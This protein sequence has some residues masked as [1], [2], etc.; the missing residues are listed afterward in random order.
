MGLKKTKKKPNIGRKLKEDKPQD[1]PQDT[2]IQGVFYI[3]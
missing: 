3:E 2:I 1:K